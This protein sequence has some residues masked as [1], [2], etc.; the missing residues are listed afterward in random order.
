MGS[1]LAMFG[2]GFLLCMPVVLFL[3]V[4]NALAAD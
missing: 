1:S 3:V 4:V 2:L